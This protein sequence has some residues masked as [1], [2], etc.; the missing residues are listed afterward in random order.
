MRELRRCMR[1]HIPEKSVALFTSESETV[2]HKPRHAPRAWTL[3]YA[4]AFGEMDVITFQNK[5]TNKMTQ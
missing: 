1:E 2:I 3:D 4:P 5:R